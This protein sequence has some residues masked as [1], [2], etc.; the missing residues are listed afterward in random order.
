MHSTSCAD[1]SAMLV[2]TLL[3]NL[4]SRPS[5]RFPPFFYSVAYG[6]LFYGTRYTIW[7]ITTLA[8][9]RSRYTKLKWEV[10]NAM[11]AQMCITSWPSP[12]SP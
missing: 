7:L 11:A 4:S 6:W 1:N 12:R 2:C 8:Y 5:L 9:Y 10:L 3:N